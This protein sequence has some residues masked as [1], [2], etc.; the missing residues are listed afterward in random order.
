MF[1]SPEDRADP[2]LIERARAHINEHIVVWQ[3][4]DPNILAALGIPPMV[5]PMMGPGG[6]PMGGDPLG[7]MT[8]SPAGPAQTA[9]GEALEAPLGV[10]PP[11]GPRQPQNPLTGEQWNPDTGGL[12]D[13]A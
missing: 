11:S 2:K 3:N 6:Q 13:V 1:A 5:A 8:N 12:Q 10:E 7:A 4:T 9:G